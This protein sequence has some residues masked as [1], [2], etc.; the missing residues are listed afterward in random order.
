MRIV[1]LRTPIAAPPARCFDLARDVM[2][3][4]R[5]LASSGERAVAGTMRG[6]LVLAIRSPGRG[7]TWG[8]VSA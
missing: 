7:G 2:L 4:T 6:L 5:T 1:R 3:H 8:C